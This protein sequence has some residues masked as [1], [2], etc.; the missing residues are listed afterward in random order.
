MFSI[1][2]FLN[3][4]KCTNYFLFYFYKHY[5][6]CMLQNIFTVRILCKLDRTYIGY[7]DKDILAQW[8][9]MVLLG[10]PGK[11]MPYIQLCSLFSPLRNI[12]TELNRS[13]ARK[14]IHDSITTTIVI[15]S[16]SSL[17]PLPYNLSWKTNLL[18]LLLL[19]NQH[20]FPDYVCAL[21]GL[22]PGRIGLKESRRYWLARLP[23][24]CHIIAHYWI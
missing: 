3:F 23:I 1:I 12:P 20:F 18:N 15:F 10:V 14:M 5:W 11:R 16:R 13:L 22:K 6:Y 9:Q 17:I 2:K 24:H 4:E 7:F 19:H 8:A 21:G